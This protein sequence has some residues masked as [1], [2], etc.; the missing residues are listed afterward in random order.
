MPSWSAFIVQPTPPFGAVFFII[1]I[2]SDSGAAK[3]VVSG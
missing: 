2:L 1:L 3:E